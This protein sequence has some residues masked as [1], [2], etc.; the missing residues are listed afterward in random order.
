MGGHVAVG[1]LRVLQRSFEVL[2]Q[3]AAHD[4]CQHLASATDAQHGH[5]LV[6][7]AAHQHQLLH[8]ALAVDAAQACLRLHA[9]Q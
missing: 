5:L 9:Q 4:G 3:F 8:I 6:K 7:G 1:F 2:N